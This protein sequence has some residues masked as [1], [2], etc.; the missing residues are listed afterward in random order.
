M[1]DTTSPAP[2]LPDQC[3]G[4]CPNSARLNL[5]TSMMRYYVCDNCNRHWHVARLDV[6]EPLSTPAWDVAG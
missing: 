2:N 4:G 3:P 5:L 6:T 1:L